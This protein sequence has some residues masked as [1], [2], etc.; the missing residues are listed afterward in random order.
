MGEKKDKKTLQGQIQFVWGHICSLSSIDQERNNISLFNVIEQINV[1]ADA[2]EMNKKEN[3]P[4]L[5]PLQ[6]EILLLFRRAIDPA[7]TQEQF[8]SVDMKVSL[9]DPLG[10]QLVEN[11]IPMKFPNSKRYRYRL[12]NPGFLITKPGDYVYRIQLREQHQESFG[13][14]H[15]IPIEVKSR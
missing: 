2:L 1:P 14:P 9:V 4:V 3:K 12:Q 6:H 13:Q 8:T 15:E 7:L 5:F 10:A 11:L